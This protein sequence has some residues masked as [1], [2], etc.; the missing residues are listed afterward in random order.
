VGNIPNRSS[1]IGS[2]EPAVEKQLEEL[3]AAIWELG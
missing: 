2:R 3:L 1:A